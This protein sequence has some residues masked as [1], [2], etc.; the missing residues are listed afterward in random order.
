MRLAS[1]RLTSMPRKVSVFV[2]VLLAILALLPAAANAAAAS[3]FIDIAKW[4]HPTKAVLSANKVKLKQLKQVNGSYLMYYVTLPNPSPLQEKSKF[5]A[6]IGKMAKANAYNPFEMWDGAKSVKVTTDKAGKKVKAIAYANMGTY[7]KAVYATPATASAA[8]LHPVPVREIDPAVAGRV[9]ELLAHPEDY[10]DADWQNGLFPGGYGEIIVSDRFDGPAVGGLKL[11]DSM[12]RVYEELGDPSF[13]FSDTDEMFYRTPDL[14]IGIQGSDAIEAFILALPPV[15]PS[16]PDALKKLIEGVN[17][18]PD[19]NDYLFDDPFGHALFGDP[20]FIHGGGS[21]G[22]N[23]AG[24]YVEQFDDLTITVYNNYA[25][26]LYASTAQSKYKVEFLDE[27]YVISGMYWSLLGHEDLNDRFAKEGLESPKGTY[28]ALYDWIN[29]DSQY[30]TIR[31]LDNS[32]QDLYVGGGYGDFFWLSDD[33]LLAASAFGGT[34]DLIR[35]TG[36]RDDV[37]DILPEIEGLEL[38]EE[39]AFDIGLRQIGTGKLQ[40]TLDDETYTVQYAQDPE[41]NWHF[42]RSGTE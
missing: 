17:R 37:H 15:Q 40:L 27:D 21:Y 13:Y 1:P 5:E 7:F 33:T 10:G 42:K 36:D 28:S 29:S 30:F 9:L 8:G 16:D 24:L 3:K 18:T 31:T 4:N 26:H 32:R 41:G 19:L 38:G 2:L 39:G 35:V 22:M 6:F 23:P 34:V 14:Y 20:G 25:G 11:G 12:D